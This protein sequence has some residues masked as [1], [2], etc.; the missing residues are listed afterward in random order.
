MLIRVR[1]IIKESKNPYTDF[2]QTKSLVNYLIKP[3]DACL[4]LD[5]MYYNNTLNIHHC[6]RTFKHH[7]QNDTWSYYTLH[8]LMDISENYKNESFLDY[9]I[10]NVYR[11]FLN[12]IIQHVRHRFNHGLLST[13]FEFKWDIDEIFDEV[14]AYIPQFTTKSDTPTKRKKYWIFWAAFTIMSG[15]LTA[16]RIYKRLNLQVKCATYFVIHALQ[17]KTLSTKHI[18]Q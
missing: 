15:L 3:R 18:V 6:V 10:P 13:F 5:T 16:Y 11:L 1:W 4:Y 12:I 14:N 7:L 9:M 2:P 17:S 8:L